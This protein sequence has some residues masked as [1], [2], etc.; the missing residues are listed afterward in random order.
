MINKNGVAMIFSHDKVIAL[1]IPL[2]VS[3]VCIHTTYI[4][5][6]SLGAFPLRE[7]LTSRTQPPL[8]ASRGWRD[9]EIWGHFFPGGVTYPA[10]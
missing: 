6:R 5:T 2:Y 3:C 8:R 1:T 7:S 10:W 9:M 4:P